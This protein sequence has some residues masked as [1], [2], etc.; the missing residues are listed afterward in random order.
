MS[1]G[2]RMSVGAVA[3]QWRINSFSRRPWHL[4]WQP[5]CKSTELL[6]SKWLSD[7]PFLNTYPRA[8]FAGRQSRGVGQY[9]RLWHSQS[10]GVWMSA[11]LPFKEVNR[12]SCIFGLASAVALSKRL[13][14]RGVKVQ[15]KWPNDVMVEKRKLAGLLPK[16]SFRGSELTLARIGIGLNVRNKPPAEGISLYEILGKNLSDPVI[17]SAEILLALD[18]LIDLKFNQE[19]ILTEA[20][21]RLWAETVNDP[22]TGKEWNIDGLDNNGGLLLS[23]GSIRRIW[24]R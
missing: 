1:G 12:S 20:V 19:N 16:M 9:G 18:E 4:R 8:V 3:H 10:G 11:A 24:N 23:R 14:Q 21:N 5:V 2:V 13:E 17:W 22:N 7:K 6:L 15:I